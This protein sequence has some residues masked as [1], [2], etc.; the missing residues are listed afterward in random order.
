MPAEDDFTV[1]PYAVTDDVH[2]DQLFNQFG[3][4]TLTDDQITRYSANA[5]VQQ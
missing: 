5:A 3:V 1:T 2:Y 4:E